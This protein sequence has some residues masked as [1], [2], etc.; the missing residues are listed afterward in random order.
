LTVGVG[1]VFIFESLEETA[2]LAVVGGGGGGEFDAGGD[3][4]GGKEGCG[5]D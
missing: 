1:G 2:G 3:G 5:E 4:R